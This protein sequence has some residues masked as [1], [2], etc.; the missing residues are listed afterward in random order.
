MA[1]TATLYVCHG[2]DGGHAR[3][4]VA[5][6]RRR[7]AQ[8]ESNT[9]RSSPPTAI[10]SHSFGR[11]RATNCASHR[12]HEAPGAQ[13]ARRDRHH[14]LSRGP[15]MDLAAE[16]IA[17]PPTRGEKGSPVGGLKDGG[18]HVKLLRLGCHGASPLTVL[19]APGGTTGLPLGLGIRGHPPARRDRGVRDLARQTADDACRGRRHTGPFVERPLTNGCRWTRLS[20][21]AAMRRS[22]H[23]GDPRTATADRSIP[24]SDP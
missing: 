12:R 8:R 3:I 21:G 24:R 4:P 22:S 9:E 15:P 5:G 17:R 19:V 10:R 14:P 13:A 2:D 1:Q 16:L 6:C 18:G 11:V 23:A 7:S 20:P